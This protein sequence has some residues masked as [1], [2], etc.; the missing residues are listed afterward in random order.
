M[1]FLLVLLLLWLIMRYVLPLVIRLVVKH[2]LKK[3]ARQ[4]GQQFGSAPFATT[5]NSGA[6]PS[7]AAPGEVQVDY[8]PPR[9]KP[10]K[11]KEFKGGDY[12]D[13]EEVK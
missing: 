6:R 8:V 4:F 13:F 10:K 3:Q 11:P 5:G 7:Q 12:V 9:E 1:K 2:L